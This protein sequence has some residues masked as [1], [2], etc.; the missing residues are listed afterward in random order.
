MK[1]HCKPGFTILSR[2]GRQE[3]GATPSSSRRSSSLLALP[4][5]SA[6][7]VLFCTGVLPA[8]A[9]TEQTWQTPQSAPGTAHFFDCLYEQN[10]PCTPAAGSGPS[11]DQILT[12]YQEALGG[13]AALAKV[14]TRV[15]A[16][17]RFQDVGTPEDEYLLRYTK[18]PGAENG[19]L[20]SIMSDSALDGTFLRW[21]NGCDEKGGWS[22][23]GRKDPSGIPKDA[24]NS[25]DGLCEQE[26]YFYGYFPLDLD[27]LRKAYQR[28]EYKGIHKIFQPAALPVGEVAGGQGPD[29]IPAASA[30]DTYLLLGV[31]AR[32]TDDYTWLYFDT[33]TGLLLRFASAGNNPNWPNPPLA[34]SS[35]PAKLSPAGDSARI[36]DL[37]QY[38]KVGDGTIAPFQFVNQGPETRVRGVIMKLIENAPVKDSVFTRPKNSLKGDRGFGADKSAQ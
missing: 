2:S 7:A 28:F 36:V 31:P 23:S 30:R 27:H 26:L 12:H 16:Q 3:G 13:A 17:R 8:Q 1:W 35:G 32:A 18:K 15:I 29:I 37:L 24:K 5:S 14:N 33:S 25:T 34:N 10:W 19:R 4:L 38:R 11:V 20:L 21:P 9:V 22:W 6:F